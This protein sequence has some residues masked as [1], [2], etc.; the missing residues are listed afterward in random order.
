MGG[1]VDDAKEDTEPGEYNKN[2]GRN[3]EG[4]QCKQKSS[5]IM[6]KCILHGEYPR[7]RYTRV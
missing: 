4:K 3:T 2:S 7:K 5:S 1:G 6:G